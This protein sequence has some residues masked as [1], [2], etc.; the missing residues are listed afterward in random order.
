M[1]LDGKREDKGCRLNGSK[2]YP[3][4]IFFNSLLSQVL[5]SNHVQNK[6][7]TIKWGGLDVYSEVCRYSLILVHI[8]P[9]Y[10]LLCLKNS[11]VCLFSQKF[12]RLRQ[13]SHTLIVLLWGIYLHASKTITIISVIKRTRKSGAFVRAICTNSFFR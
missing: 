10:P 13:S 7:I 11:R 5:S 2:H 1:F 4:S 3:N 9:V 12:P 6:I 8:V